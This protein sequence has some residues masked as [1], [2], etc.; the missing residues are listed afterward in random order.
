MEARRTSWDHSTR[1]TTSL[2]Q[3]PGFLITTQLIL[4]P[5]IPHSSVVIG[6]TYSWLF[7]FKSPSLIFIVAFWSVDHTTFHQSLP[8]ALLMR[9]YL[10]Y[11]SCFSVGFC[12]IKPTYTKNICNFN[13]KENVNLGWEKHIPNFTENGHKWKISYTLSNFF[14]QNEQKSFLFIL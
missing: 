5:P 14:I 2:E 12:A 6:V 13:Q 11:L 8:E 10:S 3:S 7:F 9:S 1:T 4:S